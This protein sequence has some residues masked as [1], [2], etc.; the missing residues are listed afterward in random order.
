MLI[1]YMYVVADNGESV[2]F[3]TSY[4]RS[5]GLLQVCYRWDE[6]VDLKFGVW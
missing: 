2:G 1:Y 3:M 4:N 5:G 6:S